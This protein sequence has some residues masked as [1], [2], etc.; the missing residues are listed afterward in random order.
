MNEIPY[1][2]TDI[3]LRLPELRFKLRQILHDK[4]DEIDKI[5]KNAV[6]TFDLTKVLTEH[7]NDKIAEGID[8]AFY[9][10]DLKEEMKSLIWVE[11]NKRFNNRGEINEKRKRL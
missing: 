10:M 4:D 11:L 2:E 8:D 3:K 1:L 6:D 9:E 7:I 5:I